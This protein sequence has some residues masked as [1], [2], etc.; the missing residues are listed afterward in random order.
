[1]TDSIFTYDRNTLIYVYIYIYAR[2][3]CLR[4]INDYFLLSFYFFL[5]DESEIK[6]PAVIL[7]DDAAYNILSILNF[8]IKLISQIYA[9]R[10]RR[11]T[12]KEGYQNQ[13]SPKRE[14]HILGKVHFRNYLFW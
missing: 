14:T 9:Y 12:I 13:E 4:R 8:V 7:A 11:R 2:V 1:M 10:I 6:L 5:L 3:I